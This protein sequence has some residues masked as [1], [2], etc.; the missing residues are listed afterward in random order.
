MEF[1]V[2][3]K[4]I[5]ILARVTSEEPGRSPSRE[6]TS[7][8]RELAKWMSCVLVVFAI[9]DEAHEDFHDSLLS[10]KNSVVA[11]CLESRYAHLSERDKKCVSQSLARRPTSGRRD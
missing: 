11:S 1:P 2:A 6:R 7:Y 4:P 3:N 5:S 9:F 8:E 10:F